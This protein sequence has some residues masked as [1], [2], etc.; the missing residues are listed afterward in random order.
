MYRR[1]THRSLFRIL[2]SLTICAALLPLPSIA[3]LVSAAV[4]RQ[5]NPNSE[6]GKPKPGKPQGTL[7][8][9]NALTDESQIEREAPPPIPSTVRSPKNDG[10]TWN[11][12]RG[13]DPETP[14]PQLDQTP[15][16]NKQ[17]KRAHARRLNPSPPPMYEDQFIQNFFQ[18]ALLRSA[19]YDETLFWN[20]HFRAA[21]NQGQASL[22]LAAVE[23]GKTIFE[24]AAYAARNR[25]NHWYVYDLYKTFLM[26]EPDAGG[27]ANWENTVP[28]YGREYVRR[29]FEDSGEFW[30]LIGTIVLS[31]SPS[32]NPASLVT[33]RVDPRNQPGNGMLPRE[34]S[35]SV[36]LIDLPGRNGLDLGL[37][38]AYSSLVWTPSG[39]YFHFDE[40]NGFPSPGFR[41]GFPTIQRKVFDP[42]AARNAFLLIT[43]TGKRV[44]LRQVG[45]SNIYEAGDSSYLQL[46]DNGN[47]LVRSTDGTQLSFTEIN[48]EFR[49]TQ[50][51][52]RNGNYITINNNAQGR[53][54]TITDTVGRVITFNYDGNANLTSIT[55]AWN[56]QPSHQ[57]VSFGW[58]T[59]N[60]QYPF[61][62]DKVIGTAQGQAL[63]VV[64]QVALNDT[65]Y[66]TFD[67]TNALQ[68]L[69]IK[70][71]FG[72]LERNA[73]SFSYE[74]PTNDVPRLFSSSVSA[75]NWSGYNNV[76]SQVTTY[77][78]VAGDGACAMTAPDGTL[79]KEFYGTG[80]QKGLV[81]LSEVWTG[82]TKQKWA[83][84]TWTQ[85]NTAVSYQTNPRVTEKNIYDA[86]GNRRRTTID[87]GPYA[88]YGLP[89]G[90]REYA[91][92]G[93]TEIRQ[94]FTDY[95]LSQAYLD[96]RII[97]LVS[98]VHLTNVVS[99]Q[100]K[101]SYGYDDPARLQAVPATATQHDT[102]YNTSF[103]ARGNVT[104]VAR[105]DVTD[106]VNPAKALTSYT[107]Y[108][109]TGTPISTT[110]ASGHQ[111]STTYADSFSD[112]VNRNTFAYPTTL[113]DADGFSSYM[114]Y[115]FDTGMTTRTQSP[116]PAGQAQGKIQTLSYNNLGQLERITTTN[117][118][119]YKRFWYGAEFTASYST[120]NNVADESYS[121]QVTDGLGRVIGAVTNHPGST[122]GYSLVNTIY[123]TMGLASSQSN[124]TEVNSS[125]VPSG[126][127][128]AGIYYT[129]QTY[130]WQGRP[131]VTTNTDSTTKEVSYAGCGCAGGEVVTVTDEGTLDAG[132]AKRRQQRVYSDV[133]GRTVKTEIL[134]WQNGTVYSAAVTT[135]NGR[136]QPEM[137]RHYS[138]PEGSPSYQETTM[139]YD[140]YGR[141]KTKHLPEQNAGTVTTWNYNADDTI[142]STVD[143]R[144]K[145]ATFSYN[146][147]HA[148]SA[149]TYSAGTPNVSFQYDA[150]GN[151]TSMTDGLGSVSYAYDQLSRLTQETRYFSGL[152]QSFAITSGYNLANEL[153][154]VGTPFTSQQ[155]NYAYDTAG[156]IDGVTASGYYDTSYQGTYPNWYPV[157]TA[158]STL[159]SNISQRA[160]G[161]VKQLT[162]GNNG[163]LTMSYNSRLAPT[164]MQ[165]SNF[166]GQTFT[167]NYT[168]Y[169]DGRVKFASDP[170]APIFDKLYKYDHAARYKES[171][172]GS[173]ARG[174]TTKDGPYR[175]TMTYDVWG[176]TTTLVK[177]VW[178][179]NAV[180]TN[181][182]YTNNRRQNWTYDA[183]GF[184]TTYSDG[185]DWYN[186]DYDAV[187]RRSHFQTML[188]VQG[189]PMV[190]MNYSYDGNSL[191]TKTVDIRR[192]EDPETLQMSTT[193]TTSYVLH[194]TVLG[195]QVITDLN[196]Q[197]GKTAGYVYVNGMLL[198]KEVFS[199]I[200]SGHWMV[201]WQH[202]DPVTGSNMV[203]AING[204]IWGQ[205][206]ID[207]FGAPCQNPPQEPFE[208]PPYL[209]MRHEQFYPIEGVGWDSGRT[210]EMEIGMA[211]YLD[212]RDMIMAREAWRRGERDRAQRILAA[213]PNVGFI[214]TGSSGAVGELARRLGARVDRTGALTVWG[215]Q[216]ARGLG[217][218]YTPTEIA[219]ME[220][221]QAMR[222]FGMVT[223]PSGEGA[224][225][226]ALTDEQG[227]IV[228]NAVQLALLKLTIHKECKD[229]IGG[230]AASEAFKSLSKLW[231]DRKFKY[232][233]GLEFAEGGGEAIAVTRGGWT[234]L[235]TPWYRFYQ[236]RIV[237][238]YLFFQPNVGGVTSHHNI[239][240]YAARAYVI[241]HEFR[242]YMTGIRHSRN[243]SDPES[244]ESWAE[245]LYSKCHFNEP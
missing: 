90:V 8:D 186:A 221:R 162:Y 167:A 156:R 170:W 168:Y 64:T 238:G 149:V 182:T 67:Y 159:A 222:A 145:S 72:A 46:T 92:N 215:E 60:M 120:V 113:T 123:N 213:N 82:P 71:Y 184:A 212:T 224:T 195:G 240:T 83:T 7:P 104:S 78:T 73:T 138:G 177:R 143:A 35:W 18:F 198:A 15:V 179:Q 57:W 51:K 36:P 65:S 85:D 21:Y 59:R 237:L 100:G 41:L 133:L 106:I 204:S 243:A 128:A 172:T 45:T 25:D 55:Q 232:F 14:R 76:P 157:T 178:T 189:F 236:H 155:V 31:G 200:P 151:K 53:I 210:G 79:Y 118:N 209:N 216:A 187:S 13:G 220:N 43:P 2:I 116:A 28:G 30:N 4:Q 44:E 69:T 218:L 192:T 241:L 154:S 107:N 88:Q 150:A 197:G 42:L 99:W 190:E 20:Y 141:L 175:H 56:G 180:T 109:T 75:H 26:R 23:F 122:G 81:T 132:V 105:W 37:T 93:T 27:W 201:H 33:A 58:S 52:D 176:N 74:T 194:S 11:G 22:K 229:W 188:Y 49:C 114:Q 54:S 223:G 173:E 62:T 208:E 203:S 1:A 228:Y 142:Q 244:Q 91:A 95:N 161:A 40:D 63:P 129:Q 87:Y 139:S 135:Y 34:V 202:I 160:S 207:T 140:G 219:E 97:G 137:I 80:W 38:L 148:I 50:V 185:S 206:Q 98:Q 166:Y 101:L 199:A 115:N 146:N 193:T 86:S 174:G 96:R 227:G 226:Q 77:F 108:Y 153:T 48:H 117:N 103:T 94:S 130:D 147:R 231:N 124:P 191:P 9:L 32:S 125:W 3:S 158:V 16:I 211:Q 171:L 235:G 112:S 144:G 165:L 225:E 84:T 234:D 164:S 66:F 214:A 183:N 131:L 89:Y 126:D 121:I 47:L 163:V 19:T 245:Q 70:N 239:S 217:F 111:N 169:N 136:H 242:H 196:Q 68:V 12:R 233:H 205:G 17:T 127:D 110:D 6:K 119:A 102:S 230:T 39:P 10:Q 181:A 29:G 61:A 134:N 152:N 24:S 5:S